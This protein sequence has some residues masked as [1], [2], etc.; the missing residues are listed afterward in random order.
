MQVGRYLTS[1]IKVVVWQGVIIEILYED[2]VGRHAFRFYK[3][4]GRSSVLRT[5]APP[6]DLHLHPIPSQVNR[7]FLKKIGFK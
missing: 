4:Y 7:I 1:I 2:T 5:V 6:V 3:L